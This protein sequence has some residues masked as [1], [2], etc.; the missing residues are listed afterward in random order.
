VVDEVEEHVVG[1]AVAV[2]GEDEQ[3]LCLLLFFGLLVF[4]FHL[5]SG[6]VGAGEETDPVVSCLM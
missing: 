6:V 3:G 2:F 4:D 1:G 5:G